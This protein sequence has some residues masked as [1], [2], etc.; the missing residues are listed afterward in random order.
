MFFV[1]E[2]GES[3]ESSQMEHP[4]L[5]HVAVVVPRVVLVGIRLHIN[6]C[7]VIYSIVVMVVGAVVRVI[8]AVFVVVVDGV[9]AQSRLVTK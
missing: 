4:V 6:L 3:V 9:R 5:I 7:C 2:W 8:V 1:L